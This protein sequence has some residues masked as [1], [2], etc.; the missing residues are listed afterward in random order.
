MLQTR[1]PDDLQPF[2]GFAIEHATTLAGTQTL[3]AL[4]EHRLKVH[5]SQPVRGA[6]NVHRFLY[7]R[8]DID[9]Q[10][11]GHSDTW[12]EFQPGASL[13]IHVPRRLLRFAAEDMGLDPDAA[14]LDFVYQ[15]RDPRLEHI[16]WALDSD[17]E[18][19]QPNGSLFTESLGL[20]LAVHL[21]SHYRP[22]MSRV[23]SPPLPQPSGLS[24]ARLKRL[25]AYI[26]EHLD[27]PLS[28]AQLAGIAAISSSHLKLQFKRATGMPVHEYVIRRRVERARAL[29]SRSDLPIGVV[30]LEA[31]FAH[32]SH[33]ARAMRR[34]LGVTPGTIRKSQGTRT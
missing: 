34:V 14:Q 33:L 3:P 25:C 15:L 29:L 19:R 4:A 28:I 31:G 9:I 2:S 7:T 10:P 21:L 5:A 27:Q 30:A 17:R 12:Q 32:Q 18:A 23:V 16:A 20:A 1:Q 22:G 6:C 13:I 11:A 24:A 8:G 26:E